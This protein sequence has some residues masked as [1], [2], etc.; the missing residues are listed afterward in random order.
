MAMAGSR[1][2]FVRDAALIAGAVGAGPM[3]R[4]AF[5]GEVPR[6]DVRRMGAKGDGVTTDTA[7]I[8]AA[9]DAA[10]RRGGGVVHFPAGRYVSGTLLLRSGVKLELD[11]D[12]VLLGSL[13]PADYRLVEPF[14][15]GV[16]TVRGY[17]LLA[18][19]DAKD[20]GVRGGMIDGRGAELQAAAGPAGGKQPSARPFLVLC[21]RSAGVAMEDVQL[22]NSSAWT[23]HLFQCSAVRVERVSI[24]SVG[25]PNNDGIDVDSSSDVQIHGC[26]IE[27]GDD[28]VCLKTTS[29]R[30][31]ADIR[32]SDCTLSTRCAAFKIGTESMGDF[33]KIRVTG[34]H[35]LKANLGAVK[36]LAVDGGSI[37]DVLVEGMTVDEA[38][39]PIFVRLGARGRTFRA[40][41]AGRPPGMISGVVLR[42]IRVA[43][44]QRIGVLLSGLPG[45]PIDSVT[46]ERVAITMSGEPIT[47]APPDPPEVPG[48]YP[49]VRMFGAELPASG[50]YARH[51]RR[52]AMASVTLTAVAG[53]T[54]PLRKVEDSESG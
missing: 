3:V 42:D 21:V 54:R 30:P 39:T 35:V 34:C 44:A 53:D 51:V 18:C 38:D 5:A 28:A 24:R 32:V 52:L 13:N 50:L 11:A 43:A 45:H 2:W 16:G 6:L 33:S 46:L 47:S 12:A 29:A 4:A 14:T 31:C 49:E 26:T 19:T 9:V 20:V 23:M 8:Q 40:G 10:A 48:A 27:T 37:S 22:R 17:A 7:A 1:R 25:L 41:D 36:L 15:D